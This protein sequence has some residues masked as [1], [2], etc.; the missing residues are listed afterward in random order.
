[1][2]VSLSK[3]LIGFFNTKDEWLGQSL[4]SATFGVG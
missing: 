2:E 4:I 1:M 3:G